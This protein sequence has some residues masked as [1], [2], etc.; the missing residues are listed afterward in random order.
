MRHLIL[1]GFIALAAILT[2]GAIGTTEAEAGRKCSPHDNACIAFLK[3]ENAQL[4]AQLRQQQHG[5]VVYERKVVRKA[6]TVQRVSVSGKSCAEFHQRGTGPIV[7]TEG[8]YRQR[9]NARVLA[10]VTPQWELVSTGL[11]GGKTYR[12][13]AC[14]NKQAFA[15]VKTF[16][17]CSSVGHYHFNYNEA[18]Q[19][20]A[21]R[22]RL[23]PNDIAR[24]WSGG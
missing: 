4:R 15:N 8:T 24:M 22:G 12:A 9:N 1:S 6:T 19:F 7:F 17:A 2:F 14:V 11:F 13:V 23:G 16:T 3:A 20:K 21:Q 18:A 10:T 5:E